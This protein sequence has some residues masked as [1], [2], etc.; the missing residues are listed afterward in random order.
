MKTF[1]KLCCTELYYRRFSEKSWKNYFYFFTNISTQYKTTARTFNQVICSRLFSEY[2]AVS[3]CRCLPDHKIKVWFS[4]FMQTSQRL[5]LSAPKVM[6]PKFM[7]FQFNLPD[8]TS[9][10]LWKILLNIFFLEEN[11]L[12]YIR[13]IYITLFLSYLEVT[14]F[15]G[16]LNN[17]RD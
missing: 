11:C 1:S 12:H 17:Y 5:L 9:E 7:I 14:V 15:Q 10:I 6:F 16:L 3:V 8:W 2:C 13:S 4:K